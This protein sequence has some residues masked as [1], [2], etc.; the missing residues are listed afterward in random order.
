MG[1]VQDF[2]DAFNRR[3]VDALL[4]C[5]TAEASYVDR[6]YR[7][8][9]LHPPR[10]ARAAPLLPRGGELRRRLLRPPRGR[11]GAPR[12]VR[13][14][15]PRGPRLPVDDGRGGRGARP[16][17]GGVDVL[18]RRERRDPP[19]RGAAD[20]LP[21]H[22]G[23][24]GRPRTGRGVPRVLRHGPGAAPARL[25]ARRARARPRAEARGALSMAL[26][27]AERAGLIAHYAAGPARLRAALAAVP[28]EALR[29]RPAP[30]EWSAHEIVCH[31]ADSET[32][33]Y[34]RIRL[35]LT[36]PEPT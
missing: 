12:D 9:P 20:P 27:R 6:F 28:A 35:L 7:P 19:E 18:L 13:A 25:R 2:A 34:A 17:D 23:V 10:R 14:H 4:A 11:R 24:R 5:F 22:V 31:C 30:G 26:S 15:V 29:W 21:R 16:R 33:A 8:P 3:D 36:E 1:L 32:S